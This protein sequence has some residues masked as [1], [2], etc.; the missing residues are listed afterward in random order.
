MLAASGWCPCDCG[1]ERDPRGDEPEPEIWG[2]DSVARLEEESFWNGGF[3]TYANSVRPKPKPK[4]EVG[5]TS[6]LYW[7]KL[8]VGDTHHDAFN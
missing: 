1:E 4:P 5:T 7:I 3:S 2:V 6:S 8:R